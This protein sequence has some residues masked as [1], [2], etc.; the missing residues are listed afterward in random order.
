MKR[1]GNDYGVHGELTDFSLEDGVRIPLS[2]D[3]FDDD[4]IVLTDMASSV[5]LKSKK[6]NKG[7]KVTYTNMDYLGFWHKPKVEAPYICIEL[8]S[9]LPSRK[10]VV[11]NL[12]TQPSLVA[13]KAK[14]EYENRF[15]IE[16]VE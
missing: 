8:W 12:E 16:V 4:A 10:G 5:T 9:S 6:S 13:L 11:E 14:C 2:H 7:I 1:L 3:M 15:T